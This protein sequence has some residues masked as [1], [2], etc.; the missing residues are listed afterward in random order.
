MSKSL[1]IAGIAAA[2][3][4]LL[5]IAAAAV[6][7]R[8]GADLAEAAAAQ[9]LMERKQRTLRIDGPVEFLSFW[10]NLGV[11]VGGVSL[12]ERESDRE[13]LAIESA[14]VSMAVA[15]LLDRRLVVGG[16]EVDGLRAA[17]VRRRDGTLNIDDL[18]S[19]DETPMPRFDIAGIRLSGGRL[20]FRD[21]RDGR[22]VVLS[23]LS[24]RTGRIANAAEGP[25][26]LAARMASD[27]SSAGVRIAARYRFDLDGK[28]LELPKFDG[29]LDVASPRLPMK[30]LDLPLAGALRLDWGR[31]NADLR[32]ATRLDGSRVAARARLARFSPPDIGLDI[33]IDRLDVDKYLPPGKA[34][35]GKGAAGPDA[36]TGFPALKALGLHGT[37]SVGRLRIAGTEADNVKLRIG[38]D[39]L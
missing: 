27:G 16:I 22:S 26:D 36:E 32:L 12:S 24:L 4:L 11:R 18:F 6:L 34:A 21:E 33:D 13:F 23:G 10:P 5:I 39:G 25:L 7:A 35:A 31:R 8:F 3:L 30:R 38:A 14:R 20:A 2:A 19:K 1:R 28:T 15:P 29:A 9:A 37:V 17:I